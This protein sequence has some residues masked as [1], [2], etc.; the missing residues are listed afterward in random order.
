VPFEW[1]ESFKPGRA[2][3]LGKAYEELAKAEPQNIAVREKAAMLF[4]TAWVMEKKDLKR[5]HELAKIV[6]HYGKE[7]AAIDPQRVEGWAWLG[8]GIE[9]WGLSRGIMNSLQLIPEGKK[10]FERALKI[11]PD[12]LAGSVPGC[13]GRAYL[14]VPG[15]PISVG[16]TKLAVQLSLEA[17]KRGPENA[18]NRIYLADVYWALGKT[19]EALAEARLVANLKPTTEV[20][21]QLQYIVRPKALELERRIKA[22]EVREKY[23]DWMWADV[24]PGLID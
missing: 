18:L 14:E 7:M 19:E 15:F 20:E 4:F 12:Y 22:G 13:L 16:D 10:A 6:I 23:F 17:V 2:V 21:K 9:I 5:R 11:D 1:D 8:L 3:A 24:M